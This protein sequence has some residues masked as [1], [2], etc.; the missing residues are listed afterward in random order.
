MLFVVYCIIPLALLLHIYW[1][2]P[3]ITSVL[4]IRFHFVSSHLWFN[5]L[6]FHSTPLIQTFV[7]IAVVDMFVRGLVKVIIAGAWGNPSATRI[8]VALQMKLRHIS[9]IGFH[10]IPSSR[11]LAIRFCDLPA[12]RGNPGANWCHVLSSVGCVVVGGVGVGVVVPFR[13]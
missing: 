1:L 8:T 4:V 6:L 10:I 11:R 5:L 7:T 3:F 13:I 2:G 12:A 9:P